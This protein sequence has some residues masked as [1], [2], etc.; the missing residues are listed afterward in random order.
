MAYRKGLSLS[1]LFLFQSEKVFVTGICPDTYFAV[2]VK[3]SFKLGEELKKKAAV[4][5][6]RA[7]K[8][9]TKVRCP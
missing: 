9:A 1:W 5:K 8:D 2:Q 4:K 3:A 6:P 7:K